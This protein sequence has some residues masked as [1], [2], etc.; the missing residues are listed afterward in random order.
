MAIP[1]HVCSD[2]CIKFQWCVAFQPSDSL[3]FLD[4][5]EVRSCY[6]ASMVIRKVLEKQK[7]TA[8]RSCLN[9]IFLARRRCISEANVSP[10]R[11]AYNGYNKISSRRFEAYR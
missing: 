9:R 3:A 4:Y 11:Q 8:I 2:A 7:E 10:V 1:Q 6:S 5:I